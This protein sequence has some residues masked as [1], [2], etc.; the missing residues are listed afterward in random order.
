[1]VGGCLLYVHFGFGPVAKPWMREY[2]YGYAT[3]SALG[4]RTR[5]I[6]LIHGIRDKGRI[7]RH[8]AT[9]VCCL[10]LRLAAAIRYIYTKAI[11]YKIIGWITGYDE[12][13]GSL[14][15]RSSPVSLISSGYTYWDLLARTEVH[16]RLSLEDLRTRER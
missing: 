9:D 4:Y 2:E 14:D 11:V 5:Q 16:E 8:N 1:M 3:D 12:P 13:P 7:S 6:V 15:S 10:L